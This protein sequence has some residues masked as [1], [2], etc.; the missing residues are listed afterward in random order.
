MPV[1]SDKPTRWKADVQQSV[2]MFNEWFMEFAPAAYRKTR[3]TTT[4]SV[5]ATLSTR[6]LTNIQPQMLREHP[7]VLPT[8]RMATCPPLAVDRLIGLS[9][10]SP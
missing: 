9:G 6:Y 4:A 10:A 5:E 3:I 8:L 7:E 2:D 1:N